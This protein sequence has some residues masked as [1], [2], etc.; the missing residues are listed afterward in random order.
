MQHDDPRPGEPDPL[1]WPQAPPAAPP[2]AEPAP[3]V[4]GDDGTPGG[5]AGGRVLPGVEGREFSTG[6]PRRRRST[7]AWLLAALVGALAGAL[8]ATAVT[9]GLVLTLDRTD[10]PAADRPASLALRGE[11][12]DIGGVLAAVQPGVVALRTEGLRPGRFGEPS[13]LVEGAGTGMVIEA[14]GL[15]LTNNHVVSGATSITASLADGRAVPATLVGSFP[16][17]DV[18]LIQAQGVQGLDT[19]ALGRSSDMQVGD[20]VVA[21]GNALAL[22]AR[23]TVTTGIVSA[24]ARSIRAENGETLEQLI[25]TDAAINPGNSGGPLVNARGEVIGVNTAIAGGAEGIGFALSIDSIGPLVDELREGGGAVR[26]GAFLGVST[27]DV[28]DLAP[29]VVGQL[30]IR[31]GQGAFVTAV[32]PGTAAAAAGLREGDV[33]VGIDGRPVRSAADVVAGIVAHEPGDEVTIRFERD[34]EV[35]TTRST[36]GAT[37]V[38]QAGD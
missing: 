21:V 1:L 32:V 18:A 13:G 4:A 26:G 7:P 28:D 27:S 31:A 3:S 9:A 10:A 20:D 23:P 36:L 22:G 17:N 16:A 35:Q 12:L 5:R 38:D 14:D 8:V 2:L 25:Q 24:V 34:G 37:A 29:D 33:I 15:I 11:A 6:G 19:V 30:G